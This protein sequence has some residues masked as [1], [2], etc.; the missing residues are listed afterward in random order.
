MVVVVVADMV[1]AVVDNR[2]AVMVAN[3]VDLAFDNQELTMG[4]NSACDNRVF[5]MEA[6]GVDPVVDIGD[7]VEEG[8]GE[9]R[10]SP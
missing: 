9:V 5:V 1:M 10:V 2:E 7:T 3:K 6:V 8:I 4:V